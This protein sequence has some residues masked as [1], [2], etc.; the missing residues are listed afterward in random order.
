M[1]GKRRGTFEV[2][3][4]TT[5]GFLFISKMTRFSIYRHICKEPTTPK[6]GS[7]MYFT[8]YVMLNSKTLAG[9]PAAQGQARASVGGW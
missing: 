4:M 8:S 9:R 6:I 2:N 7:V 1:L 5:E 3:L